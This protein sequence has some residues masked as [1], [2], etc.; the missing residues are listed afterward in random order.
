MLPA[1]HTKFE[2]TSFKCRKL[3]SLSVG[4]VN[5]N[6]PLRI[7]SPLVPINLWLRKS[8]V[9]GYGDISINLKINKDEVR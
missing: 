2:S 6:F 9:F 1:M 4:C 5:L 3:S 7:E 8:K